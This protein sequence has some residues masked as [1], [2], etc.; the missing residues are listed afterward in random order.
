MFHNLYKDSMGVHWIGS[1][2]FDTEL[3]AQEWAS[4]F[5]SSKVVAT[6]TKYELRSLASELSRFVEVE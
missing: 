6:L 2:A 5:I 3:E 4:E 1:T